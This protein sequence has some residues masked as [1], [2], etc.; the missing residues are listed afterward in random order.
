[1]NIIKNLSAVLIATLISCVAIKPILGNADENQTI[2]HMKT[3][4]GI[5]R[6]REFNVM[7]MVKEHEF[8]LLGLMIIILCSFFY[9]YK[10]G[11]KKLTNK[12]VY[13]SN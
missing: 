7:G 1:M 9:Y 8:L 12:N 13:K 11:K 5:L 3:E 6:I 2:N 10:F 4:E